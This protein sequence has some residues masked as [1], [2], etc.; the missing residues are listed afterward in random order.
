MNENTKEILNLHNIT[1]DCINHHRNDSVEVLV[2]PLVCNICKE[3]Y[4]KLNERYNQLKDQIFCMDIVDMINT[5]R[6]LWSH[7]LGCCLDRK[8]PEMIY[9]IASGIVSILPIIF[10]LS[11][12]KF[13]TKKEQKLSQRK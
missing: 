7:D 3:Q 10:Y 4:L 5:T 8:R 9:L 1:T 2:D 13:A 12:F 11:A 6:S